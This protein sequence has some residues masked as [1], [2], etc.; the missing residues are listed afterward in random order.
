MIDLIILSM[1]A[2]SFVITFYGLFKYADVLEED[3]VAKIL[4][5]AVACSSLA[6]IMG[7]ILAFTR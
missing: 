2:M 3:K 5:V 7:I 6:G 1:I 4:L